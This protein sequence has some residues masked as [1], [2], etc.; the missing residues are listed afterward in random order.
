LFIVEL[1]GSERADPFKVFDKERDAKA[2]A[3]KEA[4]AADVDRALVYECG[5]NWREGV[6]A[7][8][9]GRLKPKM[10]FP[11]RESP[12]VE[13][14]VEPKHPS[15]R[16]SKKTI[17]SANEIIKKIPRRAPKWTTGRVD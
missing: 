4:N 11:H 16:L 6:A 5:S 17:D 10:H 2:Y 7:V 15:L 8:K 9:V 14:R 1:V 13:P 3:E 12:P